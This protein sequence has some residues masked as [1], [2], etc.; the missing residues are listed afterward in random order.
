[1]RK[2]VIIKA[3]LSSILVFGISG[4]SDI[5]H[6]EENKIETFTSYFAL[7]GDVISTDNVIQ[8][9]IAEK[10][11]AICIETWQKSS[12]SVEDTIKE[13]ITAGKYPDFIYGGSAQQILVNSEALVP[14]DEYWDEYENIKNF[15]SEKEWDKLR[16]ETGHIYYIPPFNNTY[17]EEVETE[18]GGEAFW[19]QVKVLEWA[20][21]PKIETVEQ[22]F[23]LIERYLAANPVGANGQPNIGY[24]IL[25]DGYMYFCLDNPPQF[26][27]GYPD[28]GCCIVDPDTLTAKDY[29]TT[30]TAE[31]WFR[32]LN[33]EYHKGIIDPDFPFL[34]TER[35]YEK[36]AT[37]NVLGMVDQHWNFAGIEDQLPGD[38]QYVPLDLVVDKSVTPRYKSTGILDISQGIGI[39]V[40][41][42]D[43]ESALKFMNE[44]LS[45]DVLNLRFWGIEGE[46]YEVDSEG[47]FYRTD[48]QRLLHEDVDYCK[49]HFCAY[50]SFPFYTGMNQDGINAFSRDTQQSEYIN[51]LSSVMK[52]CLDAY[53]VKTTAELINSSGENASWFPMWTYSNTF[54]TDTIHGKAKSDIDNVK[55]KYLP[56]V[57]MSS[58]FEKAWENYLNEYNK[59]NLN[60]YFSELTSQIRIR[61]AEK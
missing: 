31:Y 46:D 21:F 10:T 15:Y 30:P 18:Y 58:D 40:S 51:S 50:S 25:A 26:L 28:D 60:S 4:C 38:N 39:S 23:D 61:S 1:M 52:R 53:G 2:S 43:V 44:L 57:V 22:Y 45:P 56:N 5:F 12:S 29:S 9:L 3:A 19:I 16:S 14:L 7:N 55:R 47:K 20:G 42:N 32:K 27:D 8:N 24:E 17:M 35:Y 33:Q 49:S 41:C 6:K 48:E 37:G 36:L 59:C 11:G 54:T 13:M 34:T